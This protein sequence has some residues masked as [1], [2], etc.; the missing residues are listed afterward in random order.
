[1]E[2]G[3]RGGKL[4]AER[5]ILHVDP[6][7][8]VESRSGKAKDARDLFRMEKISRFIPVDPHAAKIVS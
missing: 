8:I 6:N 7:E 5:V 2:A 1:M 3:W 4:I